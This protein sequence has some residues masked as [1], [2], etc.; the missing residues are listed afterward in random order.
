MQDM[1]FKVQN[2][3]HSEEIQKC[4][5]NLGFGWA[6]GGRVLNHRERPFLY[7]T[8][9]CD[10][11]IITYGEHKAL[12]DERAHKETTLEELKQ[13]LNQTKKQPHKH[14]EL[15]KAWADGEQIQYFDTNINKWIIA[16]EPKWFEHKQYR[17]KPEETDLEKYGIEVGDIWSDGS[18]LEVIKRI[19]SSEVNTFSTV[20]GLLC[21]IEDKYK[22]IFRRGV[23]DRLN[24]L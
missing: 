16:S 11:S 4:L 1:K 5:F 2:E 12:F 15:I 18:K 3:K 14:A 10:K 6:F 21:Q 8:I 17:I 13:M 7:G 23:I 20:S 22:L 19:C 24:E 9:E